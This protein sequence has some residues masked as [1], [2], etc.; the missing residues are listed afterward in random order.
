MTERDYQEMMKG[1]KEEQE[2]V[3][4]DPVYARE[5]LDSLGISQ[6][7]VPKGTQIPV[8]YSVDVK[9]EAVY[10]ETMLYVFL[11]N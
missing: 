8:K 4:R 11:C 3:G 5:L 7:M 10:R 1:L 9:S 6:F 2:R